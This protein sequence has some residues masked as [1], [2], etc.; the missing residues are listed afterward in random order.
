MMMMDDDEGANDT[1]HD[2]DDDNDDGD[3]RMT[4]RRMMYHYASP[5]SLAGTMPSVGDGVVYRE[6]LVAM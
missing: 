1:D 5:A 4:M 3:G 6:V 2:D